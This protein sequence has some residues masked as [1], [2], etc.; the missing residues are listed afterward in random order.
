MDGVNAAGQAGQAAA[1]DRPKGAEETKCD[2]VCT[3]KYTLGGAV[4]GVGVGLAAGG[5]VGAAIGAVAGGAIGYAS[6]E[7]LEASDRIMHPE[8][9]RDGLK[10]RSS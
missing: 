5:P 10:N 1:V 3:L 8:R 9:H 6:S 7:K 2:F 4:G